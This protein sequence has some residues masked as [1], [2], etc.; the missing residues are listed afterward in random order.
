M[1]EFLDKANYLIARGYVPSNTDPVKLAKKLAENAE[2]ETKPTVF[3]NSMDTVYGENK[4]LVK[5]TIKQNQ[6][7]YLREFN[8]NTKGEN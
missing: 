1:E 6:P 2:K 8:R 7:E 3:V 5:E 4:P